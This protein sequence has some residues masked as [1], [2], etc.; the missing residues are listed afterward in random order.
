[1]L[2]LGELLL[3]GLD[4]FVGHFADIGIGVVEQ[5][6][7]VGRFCFNSRYWRKMSTTGLRS[8]WAL[9]SLRYRS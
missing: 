1:M 7:I 2:K 8:E 5:F 9:V 4:F 3:D 6:L